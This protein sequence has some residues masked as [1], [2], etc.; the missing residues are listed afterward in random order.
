V[1]LWSELTT[2]LSVHGELILTIVLFSMWFCA[3]FPT[4]WMCS[5]WVY[6]ASVAVS[7]GCCTPCGSWSCKYVGKVSK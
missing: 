6:P 5:V 7:Y 2:K 4:L 3:Y 1:C